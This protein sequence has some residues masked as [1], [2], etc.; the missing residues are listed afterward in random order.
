MTRT[1]AMLGLPRTGKSTYIGALWLLV[2]SMVEPD[3]SE[4]NVFGD[5]THIDELAH[6]VAMGK[7]IDRTPVDT[8]EGFKVEIAI[9]NK[10]AV[11]LDIPDLSGEA[12]REVVEERKWR[13]T[14]IDTLRRADGL[15]LFVHPDK[16]EPPTPVNFGKAV[17]G[18]E[19]DQSPADSDFEAE[20]ACT[21][22]KLVELLENVVELRF[23]AWPIPV[24]V[25][26]S[27]WDRVHG[28]PKPPQWLEER[29]PGVHGLLDTNPGVVDPAVF[30]ISALGGH[31]PDGVEKLMAKGEAAQRLFAHAPDG[32]EAKL[33]DPL[34]WL[35]WRSR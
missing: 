26:V 4:V 35:L 22:A 19:E 9:A 2:Q 1:V 13:H 21:A 29:L 17:V 32:S 28:D 34:S 24:A 30:G 31:I 12:A 6:Q 3:L 7:E 27:A 25:I 20:N 5:R 8:D 23:D 15:L 10:G 33:Y 11:L 14:L 16:I 18:E